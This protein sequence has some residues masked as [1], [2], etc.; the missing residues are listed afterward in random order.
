[1]EKK[2]G[3]HHRRLL[4]DESGGIPK[5]RRAK[6]SVALV[7]PNRYHVGMSSLGFQAVYRLLNSTD[8]IVCERAFLP[9]IRFK[10]AND[11]ISLES[12]RPL[13]QFD[14]LA[15]SI[16]F[17][18]DY[19]NI[20]AIL[21][22]AGIPLLTEDRGPSHPLV[23]AGGVATF[24]NP[25]PIAP[26]IDCFFIGE[27]EMMMTP[28]FNRFSPGE[29]RTTQLKRIARQVNGIYVPSFYQS[30]YFADG[31]LQSMDPIV[32]VPEKITRVYLE[33]LD[34][35]DTCS[36]IVTPHTTFDQTH[37]IEVSRGCPHGCRFCGAGFVYR[38]PRFRSLP[39][40]KT[41]MEAGEK[42]SGKIGLVGAAVSDLPDLNELCAHA[43][44]QTKLSFSS[45]RADA[46]NSE[47]IAHMKKNAVKTATIA[48]DAGSERLRNVINKGIQEENILEA[49]E[50]L[51]ASGVPNL[52]LYFMV[53]LP[54]ETM[55]DIDAIVTI[56]KKIKHR[57]LKTSRDKKRIGTIT[58]SVNSFVPKPHTPFQWAAMEE[59]MRLK[60]K[61]KRIQSGL[62][63]VANVQVHADVPKW[64]FVQGLL[65]RGDR[66]VSGILK[67]L[68]GN[69]GN[70]VKTFKSSLINPDF[71]V[72]RERPLDEVFPWDF[73]DHG[74]SKAFLKTEYKKA[75][76]ERTTAPCEPSACSACGVCAPP[77][78]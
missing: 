28:F 4:A 35:V 23:A 7:Y 66:R 59:T 42:Q 70:W 72:Y 34:A 75:M 32:D 27:A 60:E 51:V 21:E 31:R 18:N 36:A 43:A 52:K 67:S 39:F 78:A 16:S 8:D 46:L 11:I 9:E 1:M 30:R 13:R 14:M 76:L 57:F 24:L 55:Q 40:L 50:N 20:L 53:G 48:P 65:S 19:P 61:I 58:V 41:C 12:G 29:N 68:H 56:C 44:P 73:I 69:N 17:E 71:Y 5:R 2:L 45:L 54:T 10:N 6:I 26:F 49:V 22:S 33:N 62:R 64:A 77:R 38:P 25:E 37:L 47:L 74:L 63:R 3:M 15:F